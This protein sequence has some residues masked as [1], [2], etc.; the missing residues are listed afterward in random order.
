MVMS[1]RTVARRWADRHVLRRGLLVV[2]VAT[3]LSPLIPTGTAQALSCAPPPD[4]TFREMIRKHTTGSNYYDRM[5]LGRVVAIKDVDPGQGGWKVAKVAVAASPVG[6]APFVAR[7]PFWKP[8]KSD[9]PTPGEDY[10]IN[11]RTGRYYVIIAHRNKDGT[12]DDDSECGNSE[13]VSKQQLWA[14]VRY[15]RQH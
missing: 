12:F 2:A 15:D 5:I 14:L 11:Y 3:L 13:P 10:A 9:E 1:E 8:E 7:L 6:W 4:L